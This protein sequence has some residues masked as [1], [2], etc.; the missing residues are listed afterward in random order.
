MS[1]EQE[2]LECGH[3]PDPGGGFAG[4][5]RMQDGR[6]VCGAC[7]TKH[8]LETFGKPE[9][10]RWFGY[11]MESDK[12]FDVELG[13]GNAIRYRDRGLY[14]TTWLGEP[15]V[16][17]TEHRT[18]LVGGFGGKQER[19]YWRGIDAQGRRWYG[20]MPGRHMFARMRRAKR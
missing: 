9:T 3:P 20:T 15:L 18:A 11:L 10:V 8:E 1:E 13:E 2:V 17:V 7:G 5:V 12:P 16:R 6:E 14:I 4:R 19:I